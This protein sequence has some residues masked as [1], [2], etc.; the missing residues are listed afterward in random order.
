M[1]VVTREGV[2]RVRRST[3]SPV[4]RPLSAHPVGPDHGREGRLPRT[5][6]SRRSTSSRAPSPTRSGAASRSTTG[7][8]L[9]PDMRPRRARRCQASRG[10][11]WWRAA[12][13]TTRRSSGKFMIERLA[14]IPAEVDSRSEFRYR[15]PLVGPATRWW[16]RSSQSGE[17]ADTLGA[18]RGRAA[19][20]RA[21]RGR[22]QRGRQS[23]LAREAAGRALHPR[24][25]R[26]S[27][28][29]RPRPSRPADAPS[30]CSRCISGGAAAPARR[31]RRARRTS[32][33]LLELPRLDRSTT[34]EPEG[35]IAD[36][37]RELWPLH[38]TSSILGRGHPLPARPR[39]R[40]QAEGDLL[41]PRRGL[42][43]R[44][45][46]ARAHRPDRRRTCRWWRSCRATPPT[47]A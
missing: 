16:W 46:E 29:R 15:D 7:D 12:R 36:L 21:G 20:G 24:R 5:S 31:R 23:A 11:C 13:P 3:G 2:R 44:R 27:A 17:T 18:V 4:E 10:W 35:A 42:P 43:G 41:R 28:W 45:D 19:R 33:G 9:L 32:Q 26:R 1:A 37:A 40:A 25:A 47:T 30:T 38:A 14:G 6:C 39:G 34:L 22:L 8:V